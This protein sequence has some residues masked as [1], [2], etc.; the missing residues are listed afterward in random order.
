MNGKKK[1]IMK[2]TIMNP[3]FKNETV[4]YKKNVR[5]NRMDIITPEKNNYE[6]MSAQLN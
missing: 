3:S 1:E 2:L 6:V 5:S 4:I